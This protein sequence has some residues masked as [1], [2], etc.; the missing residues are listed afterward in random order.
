MRN[1][2]ESGREKET[3]ECVNIDDFGDG[4]GGDQAYPIPTPASSHW[5][6]RRSTVLSLVDEVPRPTRPTQRGAR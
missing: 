3:Y 6:E 2:N 4:T 1:V 5:V